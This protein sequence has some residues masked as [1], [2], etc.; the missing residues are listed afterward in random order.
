MPLVVDKSNSSLS[1]DFVIFQLCQS[2]NHAKSLC[3][4]NTSYFLLMMHCVVQG[5]NTALFHHRFNF[6]KFIG[7]AINTNEIFPKMVVS[8]DGVACITVLN[9]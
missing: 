8:K 9:K 4:I 2:Y 5:E 6:T 1:V 3:Q 7:Y